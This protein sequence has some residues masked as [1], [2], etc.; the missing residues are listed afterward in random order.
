MDT[1]VVCKAHVAVRVGPRH[2][3]YAVIYLEC[4]TAT[5]AHFYPGVL[6]QQTV[7]STK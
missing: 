1:G 7:H 3:L 6:L 2:Q 4:D 5:V